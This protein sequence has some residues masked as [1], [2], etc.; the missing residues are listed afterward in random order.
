VFRRV[1]SSP[2]CPLT[3][4]EKIWSY[5]DTDALD[6]DAVAEPTSLLIKT[7]DDPW[8]QPHPQSAQHHAAGGMDATGP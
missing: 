6:T 4:C 8:L 1:L 2:C 7:P 5:L 3:G